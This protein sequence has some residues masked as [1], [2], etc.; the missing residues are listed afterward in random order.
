M[1]KLEQI[2]G[3]KAQLAFEM[4][5]GA[6]P[7][8]RGRTITGK[9]IFTGYGND[10]IDAGIDY[11]DL[12]K[13]EGVFIDGDEYDRL[14]TFLSE[15]EISYLLQGYHEPGL[16]I[17]ITEGENDVEFAPGTLV[18]VDHGIDYLADSDWGY[19]DRINPVMKHYGR[20]TFKWYGQVSQ[21]KKKLLP[22]MAV[23]VESDLDR[24]EFYICSP[25]ESLIKEYMESEMT[26]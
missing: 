12:S 9:L 22:Y 19:L 6:K 18:F 20:R 11:V 5:Y 3:I 10:K 7:A 17:K 16:Y 8:L 14:R 15:D 26:T 2:E 13:K 1:K 21:E 4:L 23:S 24:M 25:A